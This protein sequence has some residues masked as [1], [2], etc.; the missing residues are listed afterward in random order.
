MC[1]CEL[2]LIKSFPSVKRAMKY[3]KQSKVL[4]ITARIQKKFRLAS[5]QAPVAFHSVCFFI[6]KF[7]NKFECSSIFFRSL[8]RCLIYPLR[9][10]LRK[11]QSSMTGL[12]SFTNKVSQNHKHSGFSELVSGKSPPQLL[13]SPAVQFLPPCQSLLTP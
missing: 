12:S 4:I 2:N 11:Q 9:C 5:H 6:L 13:C 3:K 7:C 1:D 10:G 8:H